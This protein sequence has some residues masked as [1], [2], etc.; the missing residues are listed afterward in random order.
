MKKIFNSFFLI[1]DE[2][3]V[4][5]IVNKIRTK[6]EYKRLFSNFVSLS[7]LQAANYIF[8]LITFPYLVRVL[9]V[10]KF[11]LISFAQA[12]IQ[13]FII[14]TDYGFNLS[15]TREISI[16]RD[17]KEKVNEIFS[18][19]MIIKSG[20]FIISFI[21][22]SGIVF[23]F[24]KFRKE[25]VLYYLTFGMVLGQ[26]LF[27]VWFFQGMEQMKWITYLN[28][29]SRIIF[30]IAIFVFIKK[31]ADYILFPIF[32]SLGYLTSSVV[33]FLI[34]KNKFMVSFFICPIENLFK[35][36]KHGWDIFISTSLTTL[37]TSS[38]V[39]IL[40]IFT[41]N[42]TVGYFSSADKII[43]A[44]KGLIGSFTQSMYPYFSKKINNSFENGI[45]FLKKISKLAGLLTFFISLLTFIFSDVIVEILLGSKYQNSKIL[46][47]IMSF[48]PFVI[49]MS[50][51]Y[52]IQ[53]LLSLG[54]NKKFKYVILIGAIISLILSFIFV[55]LY[56]NMASSF[57]MLI[58]EI[59]VTLLMYLSYKNSVK[60]ILNV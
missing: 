25:W 59:I 57:I 41:D 43:Q 19:V 45:F 21:I 1:N 22:M 13:Y 17:N 5:F 56:G 50:N 3:F 27:P 8:P 32:L 42:K 40:G 26:V 37:Y 9:G 23:G 31:E 55:P 53:G 48:L 4:P 28:I 52:G 36:S 11:G 16:H 34:I 12:F 38:S 58:V 49:T 60:R 6:V 29:A 15:A 20:L 35:H 14:I 24:E 10:E 51:I 18:S 46:L 33:S 2:F 44:I 47:K 54:E 39:F 30:T 7:V